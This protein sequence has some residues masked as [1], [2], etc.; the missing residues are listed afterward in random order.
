MNPTL[1]RAVFG[2]FHRQM[3][4]AGDVGGN[5][6][7]CDW[8]GGFVISQKA[9]IVGFQKPI[10]WILLT[11]ASMDPL[12]V[13]SLGLTN[14]LSLP[15]GS[16]SSSRTSSQSGCPLHEAPPYEATAAR[17]GEGPGEGKV[18]QSHT[19]AASLLSPFSQTFRQ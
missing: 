9:R 15:A 11:N 4:K 2:C 3:A 17:K 10:G 18:G 7:G 14:G 19:P 12:R 13:R 1:K 8:L 6:E 5:A 16:N